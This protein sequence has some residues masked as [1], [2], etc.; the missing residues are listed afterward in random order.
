MVNFLLWVIFGALAGWLVGGAAQTNAASG[1]QMNITVGIVGAFLGG[2]SFD[3]LLNIMG[4]ASSLGGF[5][6]SSLLV[7]LVGGIILTGVVN[8]VQRDQTR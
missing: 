8:L 5:S 7:A 3:N 2:L 1:L 6:L 4:A